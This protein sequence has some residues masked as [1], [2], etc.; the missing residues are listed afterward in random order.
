MPL[1]GSNFE[2]AIDYFLYVIGRANKGGAGNQ[3]GSVISDDPS[4][5]E[6]CGISAYSKTGKHHPIECGNGPKARV[7]GSAR[8]P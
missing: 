1:Y 5:E 6:E 7:I 2:I 4:R 8:M 3:H